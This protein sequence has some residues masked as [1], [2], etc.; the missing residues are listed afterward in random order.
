MYCLRHV[1]KL[2]NVLIEINHMKIDI[3]GI[4]EIV[5][6]FYDAAKIRGI[7][8]NSERKYKVIC[9]GSNKKDKRNG[10]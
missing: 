8:C 5:E 1:G 4:V 10:I 6:T 2:E 9:T 7:T 3:M